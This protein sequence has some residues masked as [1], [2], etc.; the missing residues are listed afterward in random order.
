MNKCSNCHKPTRVRKEPVGFGQLQVTEAGHDPDC[1][2]CG[3]E[4]AEEER[5]QLPESRL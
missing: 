1:K 4:W 5:E 3:K 2:N